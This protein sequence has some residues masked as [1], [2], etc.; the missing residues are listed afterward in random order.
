MRNQSDPEICRH[1]CISLL[2]LVACLTLPTTASAEAIELESAAH[3]IGDGFAEMSTKPISPVTVENVSGAPG[4]TI[5]LAVT[6]SA[7]PGQSVLNTYLVG[8]PN[9][10]RLADAEHAVT[11]TDEKA[12]IDVTHWDLSGLSVMLAPTQAGTYT[13]LVIAVSRLDDSELMNFTNSTFTL[14]ANLDSRDAGSSSGTP[15]PR[16]STAG[17][18]RPDEA[19]VREVLRP[20]VT[21]ILSVTVPDNKTVQVGGATQNI[22]TP[23]IEAFVPQTGAKLQREQVP[24]ADTVPPVVTPPSA[25]DLGP[26]EFR[27]AAAPS[28]F[29]VRPAVGPAA[30]PSAPAADVDGKALVERAEK[31]IRLG[32]ISGARL[33]LERAFDRG[34]PRATF[35]L[36]QTCAPRML[37][38]WKVQGLKPDPDRARALYAKAAEEGVRESKAATDARR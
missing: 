23:V 3:G 37:R 24:G 8:L 16:T 25:A 10:A 36:A 9:G 18:K 20:P 5:P 28:V 27:P 22:T 21:A 13:L 35:L 2:V 30:A 32:D 4:E 31:L 7:R 38:E 34:D 6:V 33:V 26:T 12:A 14:K 17:S 15:A 11:A 29:A 1:Q 19:V